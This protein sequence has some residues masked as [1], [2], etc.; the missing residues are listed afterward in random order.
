MIRFKEFFLEGKDSSGKAAITHLSHAE[1][2]VIERGVD[3]LKDF[4]RAV[5]EVLNMDVVPG[6]DVKL[7]VKIDGAP[8]IYF[9]TDPDDDKFFV[10]TKGI[11]NKPPNVIKDASEVDEKIQG[12]KKQV[13]AAFE[14][15]KQLDL[16][17]G[18]VYQG[19]TLFSGHDDKKT[20][21]IEG[22]VTFT[23]NVITYAIPVDSKSDLYQKVQ[24]SKY[25]VAVHT[26]YSVDKE[27]KVNKRGIPYRE[28]VLKQITPDISDLVYQS[29]KIPG[30]YLQ[31]VQL[32]GKDIKNVVKS[33]DKKG[34]Q[35]KLKKLNSSVPKF[36]K[37]LKAI[38]GEPQLHAR[39]QVFLNSQLDRPD[40]GI[41]KLAKEGKPFNP[42]TFIEELKEYILKYWKK[43]AG[44]VKTEKS[45]L[46]KIQKGFDWNKIIDENKTELIE[47]FKAY[48][49]MIQIKTQLL[50]TFTN[51]KGALNTAFI[52][53][54]HG[55]KTTTGEGFVL[56]GTKNTIKIV[57]RLDFSA[58]NRLLGVSSR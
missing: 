46:A 13:K 22:H 17:P 57:D 1:D 37:A 40:F 30:L 2:L 18:V 14:H 42:K 4:I 8:A 28:F 24:N 53:D 52:N 44:K 25:G 45:R 54:G 23:P 35:S 58:I 10:A 41:F 36:K 3:G 55:F 49:D 9:G 39:L 20:D 43:E 19:D 32:D 47:L 27:D 29:E 12:P 16:E 26:K 51:V 15:L 50:D 11:K 6:G 38:E 33:L 34:I 48:Y 5:N 56:I 31:D 21:E 7:S